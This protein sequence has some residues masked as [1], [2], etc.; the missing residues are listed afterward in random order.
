M[1]WGWDAA[2]L[3]LIEYKFVRSEETAKLN[4]ERAK[5]SMHGLPFVRKPDGEWVVQVLE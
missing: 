2:T 5:G 1:V 4:F 3:F